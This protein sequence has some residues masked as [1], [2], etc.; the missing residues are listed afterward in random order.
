VYIEA[1]RSIEV[2]EELTY[3][4]NLQFEGKIDPKTRARYACLCG[5]ASCRG[6]MLEARPARRKK[7]ARKAPRARG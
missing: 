5:T 6:T 2:G 4:Y 3:D 1:L 7:S